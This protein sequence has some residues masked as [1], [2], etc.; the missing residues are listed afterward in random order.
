MGGA[1]QGRTASGRFGALREEALAANLAIPELGLAI[2]TWGN[3]SA[4]DPGE[5]VFA[6][7]PSGVEYR[8]LRAEDMVVV[9][10]EGRVVEGTGR[11]SS[12]TRTHLALYREFGGIRGVCHTHSAHAVAWAQ[13]RLDIPCL[14]TTHADQ[15]AGPVPCTAMISEA[16]VER[17]YEL[18]TGELI[19]RTFSERGLN[20]V[21]DP[22]VLVAGHGPFTWG[23]SAM[24]A[25]RNAAALE[26][27]A[28]MA[29]LTMAITPDP[30]TLPEH[31]LHK[32][33]ER[34]HGPN[35][36]YGQG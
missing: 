32:H 11:P 34:K 31:V 3:A 2:L 28:R 16:E 1:R 27:V 5:G 21:H 30:A 8:D 36:Y 35:A 20:P 7:K 17:D 23:P 33:W 26:E 10:L 6:I 29:I 22:L 12:D 25:V 14:G 9:D 13:A 4:F 15:A 19:A 18:C 24:A